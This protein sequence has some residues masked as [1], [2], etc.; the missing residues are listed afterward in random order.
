MNVE[1]QDERRFGSLLHSERLSGTKATLFALRERHG[2][3]PKFLRESE[4]L[5]WHRCLG[6]VL[7]SSGL[8]VSPNVTSTR[9]PNLVTH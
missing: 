3:E 9:G 2:S 4:T 7:N 1:A 5:I 8:I 6:R